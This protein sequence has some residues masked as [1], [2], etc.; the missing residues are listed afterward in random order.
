MGWIFLMFAGMFEIVGV[1]GM[2][3]INKA[4]TIRSFS[5]FIVG[6]VM[7][8]ALLSLAMKSLPMGTSYAVWTGI[9]TVGGAVVGM[10]YYGESSDWKRIMFI[11]M[12]LSAAVG[13]KL[14]S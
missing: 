9:G 10:L 8:F 12:V 3:Q 1:V 13:L 6:I 4:K 2:N 14:I 7:S 11:A 5:I